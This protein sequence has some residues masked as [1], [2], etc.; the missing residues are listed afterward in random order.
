MTG[1]NPVSAKHLS[2]AERRREIAE[3]LAGL[4]R[5]RARK[6]SQL[7]EQ[8][9]ESSLDCTGTQRDHAEAAARTAL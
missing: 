5:L 6:S 1:P 2:A 3:I 7:S 4:M 9:I 8:G